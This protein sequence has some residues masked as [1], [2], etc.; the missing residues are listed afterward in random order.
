MFQNLE[1]HAH[2]T[3]ENTTVALDNLIEFIFKNYYKLEKGAAKLVNYFL[4]QAQFSTKNIEIQIDGQQVYFKQG[5]QKPTIALPQQQ[6]DKQ[7]KLA[8]EQPE[9]IKGSFRILVE[10]LPVL[11]IEN[12]QVLQDSLNMT[13][14]QSENFDLSANSQIDQDKTP[15]TSITQAGNLLIAE[16]GRQLSEKISAFHGHSYSYEQNDGSFSIHAYGR[17]AVF[18]DGTFTAI[19]TQDDQEILSQL[20]H[21][22]KQ[23]LGQQMQAN[24]QP[25]PVLKV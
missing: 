25:S 13:S 2:S 10:G 11:D 20:P 4:D 23:E 5:N 3:H 22:V 8:Q 12:G 19:A 1:S 6:L 24:H 7:L 17:G 16:H 9:L 21:K 18:K 14:K 15:D